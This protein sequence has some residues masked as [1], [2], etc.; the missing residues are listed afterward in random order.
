MAGGKQPLKVALLWALISVTCLGA[1]VNSS[2]SPEYQ[3]KAAFL[4]N[5]PNFVEW[6]PEAF[7]SPDAPLVVG[8]FGKD[9]FEGA[10]NDAASKI[11]IK[12]RHVLIRVSSEPVVLRSCH[13]IFVPA[14]QMRGETGR[15]Q[16]PERP[17]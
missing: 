12:G 9:P 15:T 6:P 5:F 14:S 3:L 8:V 17:S 2:A 1:T 11:I 4:L 16:T 13:V 10:L 7:T